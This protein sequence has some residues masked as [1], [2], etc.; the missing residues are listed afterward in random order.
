MSANDAESDGEIKG[1]KHENEEGEDELVFYNP[2]DPNQWLQVP[3]RL[4]ISNE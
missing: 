2:D 4:Y 1:F 3:E